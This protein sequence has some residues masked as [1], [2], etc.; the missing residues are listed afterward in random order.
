MNYR[1]LVLAF[2][3]TVFSAC[4]LAVDLPGDETTNKKTL[5]LLQ[6]DPAHLE[7][8][9]QNLAAFRNLPKDRQE[10][11]RKFDKMLHDHDAL[12]RA[13]LRGI[14]ERYASW[15]GRLRDEDR[16]RLDA[17]DPGPERVRI[18][19]E[20]LD[21]QWQESLPRP[22]KEKL[23]KASS[24]EKAKLIEQ[25]R[26][27]DEERRKQRALARRAAEESA[28]F[29]PMGDSRERFVAFVEESLR[30]LLSD[31]DEKRLNTLANRQNWFRYPELFNELARPIDPLPFPGPAPPGRKK[32]VRTW[33]DLPA[34]IQA[35][36]PGTLP[37]EV[38]LAKGKWPD[39]ALALAKY[40]KVR[41]IEVPG[42]VFGPTRAEELPA[43]VRRFLDNSLTGKLTEDDGN[44]LRACEGNWPD[45]PKKIK[46]LASKHQLQVPGLTRPIGRE[47]PGNKN[48]AGKGPPA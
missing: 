4:A 12:E 23:A 5:A 29:G 44:Q 45:Y 48:K 16:A 18:V 26:Q 30:P 32:A 46:E 17:V 3:L 20:L 13:R 8:L 22:D 34:E 31:T 39:F 25:L 28:A 21:K 27:E 24:E 19:Q 10:Q 36:F 1:S 9:R 40:A 7:R 37:P 33:D 35:K 15:V 14:M 2:L 43:S 41:G 11:Y 6:A 47:I 42:R 38:D